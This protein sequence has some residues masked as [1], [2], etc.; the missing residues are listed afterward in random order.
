[1][2]KIISIITIFFLF[3][4]IS[5]A[6]FETGNSLLKKLS[7]EL[8]ETWTQEAIHQFMAMGYIL[9]TFDAY[10]GVYYDAPEGMV[11]KQIKDIAV[12]YIKNHPE[13]RHEPAS[14]L[15]LKAFQEA[16]PEKEEKGKKGREVDR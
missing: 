11:A 5:Y 13:S 8:T 12:N 3:A 14:V 15:L 16:F 6:D 9:G 7:Y 4:I 10:N 1:M 2:K